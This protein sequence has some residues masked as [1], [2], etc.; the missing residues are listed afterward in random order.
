MGEG[1]IIIKTLGAADED[2]VSSFSMASEDDKPLQMFI[3]RKA[4][5]SAAS[6]LTQTYVAKEGDSRKVI[7]YISVMCAE[8]KLGDAYKIVDKEDANRWES[9]PAV[10]IAR[11]ACADTHKGKGIGKRLVEIV[12]GLTINSICPTVGCR[13]MILD[14]KRKSIQFYQKLGFRL[15]DTE[16]NRKSNMPVM[17]LDLRDIADLAA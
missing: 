9:Q 12:I 5:L 14:A 7:A 10:R 4:R 11:L 17:F 13:F 8:V 1:E 2:Q 6:K 16:E 3:R 15:L